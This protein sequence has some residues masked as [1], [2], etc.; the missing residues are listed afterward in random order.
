M[1][2]VPRLMANRWMEVHWVHVGFMCLL[3]NSKVREKLVG[4]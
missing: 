3:L 4:E 1:P 2:I